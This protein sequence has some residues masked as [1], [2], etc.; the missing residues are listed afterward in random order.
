[1]KLL[2]LF[3]AD[4]VFRCLLCVS[5]ALLLLLSGTTNPIRKMHVG[6]AG[7]HP[8]VPQIFGPSGWLEEVIKKVTDLPQTN[9]PQPP[10]TSL[11]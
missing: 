9:P 11:G 2:R 10:P 5:K 6:K 4:A 7:Q 1:M 3:F 8:V